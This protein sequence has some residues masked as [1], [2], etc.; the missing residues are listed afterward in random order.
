MLE[1][2]DPEPETVVLELVAAIPRFEAPKHYSYKGS[3]TKGVASS[4][5]C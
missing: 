3:N 4:R 5:M 1:L 2:I